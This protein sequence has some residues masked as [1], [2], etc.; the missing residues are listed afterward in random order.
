MLRHKAEAPQEVAAE[1]T[2]NHS[3]SPT[4]FFLKVF[5][6]LILLAGVTQTVI[7]QRVP[8]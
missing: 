6:F 4:L 2:S 8:T 5:F 7:T 1:Q 3:Q